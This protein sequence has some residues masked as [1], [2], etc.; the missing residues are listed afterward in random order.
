M[1][2]T[3]ED[4][5]YEIV[6]VPITKVRV[7]C[8]NSKWYVEYRRKN[9]NIFT[10]W[11]WFDDSIHSSYSE[12]NARAQVLTGFGYFEMVKRKNQFILE[13]KL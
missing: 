1:S 9:S 4:L 10:K 6:Q 2:M 5:G 11:W 8:F 3:I 12:A 13:V 7:S